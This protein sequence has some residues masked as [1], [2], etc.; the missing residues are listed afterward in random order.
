M[1]DGLVWF[2]ALLCAFWSAKK[3]VEL[4]VGSL[5]RSDLFSAALRRAGIVVWFTVLKYNWVEIYTQRTW[6]SN[7]EFLLGNEY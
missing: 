7:F 3:S 4:R 6:T 2:H 5:I 1:G